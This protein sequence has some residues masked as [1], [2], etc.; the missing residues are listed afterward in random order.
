V[1]LLFVYSYLSRRG[2]FLPIIV[3]LWFLVRLWWGAELFGRTGALL[4]VWF[5]LAA[6][7]QLSAPSTGLW[8]VGFLG[9]VALAI[10]LVLKQRLSDIV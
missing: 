1:D 4:C 10:V 2:I 9:Q 6:A 5:V 7:A 8:V 3:S